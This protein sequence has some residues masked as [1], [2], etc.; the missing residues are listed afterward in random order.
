MSE[1]ELKKMKENIEKEI[2]EGIRPS[3]PITTS[4]SVQV[5]TQQSG[6]TLPVFYDLPGVSSHVSRRVA[7]STIR[8]K[9]SV[10]I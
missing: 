2:K 6:L 10:Q 9:R 8:R 7:S 3:A 4:A 5:P 1:E